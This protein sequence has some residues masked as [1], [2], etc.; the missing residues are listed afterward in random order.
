VR[1]Y[2]DQVHGFFA[3]VTVLPA[4]A[5][6]MDFLAGPHMRRAHVGA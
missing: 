2:P 3:M 4:S 6:A 1:A 5:D